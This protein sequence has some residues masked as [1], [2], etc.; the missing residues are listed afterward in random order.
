MSGSSLVVWVGQLLPGTALQRR[1]EHLVG[2]ESDKIVVSTGDG[3]RCDKPLPEQDSLSLWSS[4]QG[5][6]GPLHTCQD[7]YLLGRT[8]EIF[9]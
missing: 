6:L 8:G 2:P 9:L 7:C 5:F 3:S 4:C 1:N